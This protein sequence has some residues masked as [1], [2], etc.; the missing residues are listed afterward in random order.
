MLLVYQSPKP[1]PYFCATPSPQKCLLLLFFTK[2]QPR[3]VER[4]WIYF[5]D[6]HK[7]LTHPLSSPFGLDTSSQML[8]YLFPSNNPIV[9]LIIFLQPQLKFWIGTNSRM[10]NLEGMFQRHNLSWKI[11]SFPST[12]YSFVVPWLMRYS[13]TSSLYMATP[14]L[15]PK[16]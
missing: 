12:I 3:L 13:P 8:F 10:T 11:S 9:A 15:C 1:S 14:R 16:N 4:G 2:A 7:P 5:Y 6:S